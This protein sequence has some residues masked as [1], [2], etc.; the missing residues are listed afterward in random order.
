MTYYTQRSG[1]PFRRASVGYVSFVARGTL[2][3]FTYGGLQKPQP[4]L[5]SSHLLCARP[6][7][8]MGTDRE[9]GRHLT[10]IES[11]HSVDAQSVRR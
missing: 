6:L 4:L 5:Y 10:G 7:A 1:K 2:S 3:G 8:L 9:S 11:S